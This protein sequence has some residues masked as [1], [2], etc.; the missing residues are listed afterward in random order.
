[1]VSLYK[2][3]AA[4]RLGAWAA[5]CCSSN[6]GFSLGS[7]SLGSKPGNSRLCLPLL[8]TRH[9]L[10][11]PREWGCSPSYGSAW[12][13]SCCASHGTSPPEPR[14]GSLWN[15]ASVPAKVGRHPALGGDW[16]LLLGIFLPPPAQGS[17]HTGCLLA[18]ALCCLLLFSA[19]KAKSCSEP[20]AQVSET[21]LEEQV[22]SLKEP[23]QKQVRQ[24]GAGLRALLHPRGTAPASL[25]FQLRNR[26]QKKIPR[27]AE[28]AHIAVGE[29]EFLEQPFTAFIRLRKAVVLGSLAEVALPSR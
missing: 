21:P 15:M 3:N 4:C 8:Q 2:S 19:G 20:R 5:L 23:F 1:M 7:P 10:G 18:R 13:P 26:L 28:A 9:F 29:V 17:A 22:M 12:Q 25:S 11:S 16:A 27:G 6:V 14:C 24:D